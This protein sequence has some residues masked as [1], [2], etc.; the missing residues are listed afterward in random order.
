VCSSDLYRE[1]GILDRTHLH[2][3]TEKSALEL[4]RRAGITP[5][6]GVITGP[7]TWKGRFFDRVTCGIFRRQITFQYVFSSQKLPSDSDSS[8]RWKYKM[9]S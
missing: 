7:D 8:V 9:E 2:F 1:E 3:Y 5:T 4:A 6:S